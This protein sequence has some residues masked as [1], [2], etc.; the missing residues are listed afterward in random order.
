MRVGAFC[1]R[2]G[3]RDQRDFFLP[4][5]FS[6][7]V[8]VKDGASSKVIE[9]AL[10]CSFTITG[11][12]ALFFESVRSRIVGGRGLLPPL[13]L[14]CCLRLLTLMSSLVR[15][16]CTILDDLTGLY[17]CNKVN[18]SF[19]IVRVV[20]EGYAPVRKHLIF[21]FLLCNI[22]SK[23]LHRIGRSAARSAEVS[24]CAFHSRAVACA[25]ARRRLHAGYSLP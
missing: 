16:Y 3:T 2:S 8:L 6:Q 20:V 10:R 17:D 14:P 24:G 12:I 23:K 22:L 25:G 1:A 19:A 13:S 11:N 15:R 21:C 4:L 7:G 9:P 18:L 5:S